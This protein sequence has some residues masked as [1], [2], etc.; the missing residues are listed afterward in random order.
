MDKIDNAVDNILGPNLCICCITDMIFFN[1][2]LQ[3]NLLN[4]SFLLNQFLCPM[5]DQAFLLDLRGGS[6]T[7]L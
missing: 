1:G 6:S 4:C 3:L 2:F 7:F 5:D